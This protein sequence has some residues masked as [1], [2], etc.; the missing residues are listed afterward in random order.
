MAQI[1]RLHA[2]DDMRKTRVAVS[3]GSS[4]AYKE[5]T[6]AYQ[7]MIGEI[8]VWKQK[9]PGEMRIDP[10]TGLDPE[11]DIQAFEALHRKLGVEK[12]G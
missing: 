1:E 4:E 2:E 12:T 11:F 3:V 6:A 8:Y 9:S 5:A 7:T 10:E